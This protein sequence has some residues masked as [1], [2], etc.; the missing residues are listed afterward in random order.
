MPPFLKAYIDRMSFGLVEG[1]LNSTD[2]DEWLEPYIIVNKTRLV[3]FF[4]YRRKSRDRFIIAGN[5]VHIAHSVF[6]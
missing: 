6:M 1:K 5:T 3:S 4:V 2:L